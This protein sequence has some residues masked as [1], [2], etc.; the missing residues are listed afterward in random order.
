MPG[1]RRKKSERAIACCT[2][3]SFSESDPLTISTFGN[4]F[5]SIASTAALVF[6]AQRMIFAS[7]RCC[8]RKRSVPG[9]WP[10]SPM[11]LVAQAD[12]SRTVGRRFGVSADTHG[13][14]P[15]TRPE[16][17]RKVRREIIDKPASVAECQ[18]SSASNDFQTSDL[19]RTF[20]LIRIIRWL[21]GPA[22]GP[23]RAATGRRSSTDQT[24]REGILR[25]RRPARWAGPPI[26][27]Q[28]ASDSK[29]TSLIRTSRKL[30]SVLASCP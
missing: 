21:G 3:P 19:R 2:G 4:R 9:V 28:L 25:L 27:V 5:R 18:E 29:L 8:S 26:G 10:M 22:Q 14:T 24:V 16:A 12:W 7:G 23:G 1:P 6:A 13:A 17:F 15:R 11:F 30:A 20:D